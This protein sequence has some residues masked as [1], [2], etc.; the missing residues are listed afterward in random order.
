MGKRRSVQNESVQRVTARLQKVVGVARGGLSGVLVVFACKRGKDTGRT[1]RIVGL[2]WC[3]G[4]GYATRSGRH[5][6]CFEGVFDGVRRPRK[7]SGTK[8]HDGFSK[9]GARQ[10]T[11]RVG[12]RVQSVQVR[13]N[14]GFSIQQTVEQDPVVGSVEHNVGHVGQRVLFDLDVRVTHFE[15]TPFFGKDR[16]EARKIGVVGVLDFLGGVG[17]QGTYRLGVVFAQGLHE[18]QHQS[19]SGHQKGQE[20][21][22]GQPFRIGNPCRHGL[23]HVPVYSLFSYSFDKSMNTTLV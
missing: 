6:H 21:E 22:Q 11:H 2:R 1:D 15:L 18:R 5:G 9:T 19:G 10:M 8:R 23:D 4:G 12:F 16:Q 17:R 13:C 20:H 14:G 3:R 7:R